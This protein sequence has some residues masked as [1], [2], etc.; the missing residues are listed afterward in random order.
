MVML[1]LG[2]R[3]EISRSMPQRLKI[4]A[5]LKNLMAAVCWKILLSGGKLTSQT[6]I[7]IM[8]GVAFREHG[9]LRQRHGVHYRAE[10]VVVTWE[11]YV[12]R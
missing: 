8:T 4:K 7:K 12:R 1:G 11:N 9:I 2:N 6:F 10:E 5:E 3:M